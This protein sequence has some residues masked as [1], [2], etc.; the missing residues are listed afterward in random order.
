M[1]LHLSI[2]GGLEGCGP[3]QPLAARKLAL[4]HGA[5]G[6]DA[7]QGIGQQWPSLSSCTIGPE[8]TE[9]ELA[10]RGILLSSSESAQTHAAADGV[11]SRRAL[12][13]STFPPPKENEDR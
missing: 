6:A 4:L 5:E 8:F 13:P 11:C 7:L 1:P 2:G 3:S 10:L 12:S 9:A